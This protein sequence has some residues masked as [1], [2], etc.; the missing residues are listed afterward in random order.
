MQFTNIKFLPTKSQLNRFWDANFPP[1]V[2]LTDFVTQISLRTKISPSK[3]AFEKYK[4]RG[5]FSEFYVILIHYDPFQNNPYDK[6]ALQVSPHDLMANCV[7][8]LQNR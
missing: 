3:R 4:P 2:S 5:F 6:C 8:E 1:S 7:H